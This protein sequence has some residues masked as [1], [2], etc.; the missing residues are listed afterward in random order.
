MTDQPPTGSSGAREATQPS[1]AQLQQMQALLRAPGPKIHA[2]G[3][4][5]GANAT[6]VTVLLFDAEQPAGALVIAYPLA[7]SLAISLNEAVKNFEEKTGEEVKELNY[8][9]S[10]MMA[11]EESK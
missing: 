9:I 5:M 10:K 2:N 3:F 7:K 11:S 8:L 4:G 1:Q 6:D